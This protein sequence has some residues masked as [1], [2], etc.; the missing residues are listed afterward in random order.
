MSSSDEEPE[1]VVVHEEVH[2]EYVEVP[3]PHE[4]VHI[5]VVESVQ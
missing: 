1:E 2:V 3:V 5:D 4:E